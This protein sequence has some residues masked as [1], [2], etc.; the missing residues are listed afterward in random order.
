MLVVISGLVWI[1]AFIVAL[2]RATPGYY[3]LQALRS[4]V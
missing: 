4:M 2:R 1:F 3:I